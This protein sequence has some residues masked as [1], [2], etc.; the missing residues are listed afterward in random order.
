MTKIIPRQHGPRVHA[1][2]PQPMID[3]IAREGKADAQCYS[4]LSL[5][6]DQYCKNEIQYR[7]NDELS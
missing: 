2:H 7:K 1:K 5:L 3:A 6:E 4:E